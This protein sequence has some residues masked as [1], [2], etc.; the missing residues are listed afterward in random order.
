[1]AKASALNSAFRKYIYKPAFPI[2]ISP[3]LI[4]LLSE[5]KTLKS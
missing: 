4:K 2:I 5:L 3:P 1:M